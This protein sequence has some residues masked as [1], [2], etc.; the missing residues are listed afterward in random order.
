MPSPFPGMDPYI[1][2]A[3]VWGDFHSDLAAEI[4][5][6]LN[7]QLQP[8]YI[9][10]IIPRVTYELVEIAERRNVRPD[11]GVWQRQPPSG[12]MATTITSMP[13]ASVESSIEMEMPFRLSSVEIREVNTF[14]LVTAIEILSPVNKRPG[15]DAYEEYQ[16]KR[17]ELLRSQAHLLEID[18][19]RVGT[20]PPLQQPVPPAP[21][22]VV[23]SR[24]NKRPRVEVW[25]IQ[26][27]DSLPCLPVPLLEPD[28]DAVLD[29]GAMTAAVYERGAYAGFIEYQKS[30]PPPVFE[31]AD[32]VW[33]D[34]QLKEYRDKMKG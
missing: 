16:R 17:R 14:Q 25:P 31:Q 27:W 24:A 13:T 30:P 1:E 23:L 29:L 4:R 6:N 9:A 11:V 7:K 15:Q 26:L 3:E 20:R 28:P 10:R 5:A 34:R 8:R 21:Y 18:L 22:Y 19:L 33:I 32:Q 2:D 12:G